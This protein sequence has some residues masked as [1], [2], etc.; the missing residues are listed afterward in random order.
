MSLAY[1]FRSWLSIQCTAFSVRVL[2][3]GVFDFL[4]SVIYPSWPKTVGERKRRA[5]LKVK[6]RMLRKDHD[7]EN[8]LWESRYQ[9]ENG[10]RV[11]THIIA[12]L[13]CLFPGIN[14][15][16]G[17]G[18]FAQPL[19]RRGLENGLECQFCNISSH[20]SFNPAQHGST[21]SMGLLICRK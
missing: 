20:R 12:L 14:A 2:T 1:C 13:L 4:P 11:S 15:L 9:K 10:H 21:A 7:W 8:T 6:G 17:K 3:L 18:L 19:V 5:I 16:L